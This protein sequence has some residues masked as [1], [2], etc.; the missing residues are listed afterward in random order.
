MRYLYERKNK[1]ILKEDYEKSMN[2]FTDAAFKEQLRGLLMDAT[3]FIN[4]YPNQPYAYVQ[5][6]YAKY[7]Y[8]HYKEI[9]YFNNRQYYFRFEWSMKPYD[10]YGYC[11]YFEYEGKDRLLLCWDCDIDRGVA[12][13]YNNKCIDMGYDPAGWLKDPEESEMLYKKKK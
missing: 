2:Y 5:D 4:C 10:H 11:L 6:E 3:E 13:R 9:F 8:T 1:K 12:S 7:I